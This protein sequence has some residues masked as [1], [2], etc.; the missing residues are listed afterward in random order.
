M[1]LVDDD[2]RIT[3]AWRILF[4][5]Q[6]TAAETQRTKSFLAN[7]PASNADKWTAQ[8]RVLMASNEFLHID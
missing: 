8:L 5:R 4:Q 3:S 2:A 6:P 1:S 7:Y